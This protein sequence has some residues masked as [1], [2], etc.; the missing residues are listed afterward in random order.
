MIIERWLVSH[1]IRPEQSTREALIKISENKRGFL[2]CVDDHFHVLGGVT[3][4]DIRRY[5]MNQ[6]SF[7]LDTPVAEIFNPSVVT[8]DDGM[9]GADI[10]ALFS[11]VIQFVP[12]VDKN[13]HLVGIAVPEAREMRFGDIT[14]SDDS[15]CFVIAEIGINHNGSLELAKQLVDL[16]ADSGAD[17]AK[18]QMRDMESLYRNHS[19][20]VAANEDLGAQY[21]LDILS[22]SH[23][24][25]DE[26]FEVFDYCSTRGLV[27]LCTPWDHKSLR[28]LENYGIPGYKIASADLTNHDLLIAVAETGR[29]IIMSTGMSSDSEI[30]DSCSL[31]RQNNAQFALL[32]CNSTY[33]APFKD[34]NLNYLTRLKSIGDCPVGYS[35]HERGYEVPVAAV[36][37]GAKIVEK[38]FTVDRN[39]EGNDHRVSLLPG[40]FADMVRS[41]RNVE[42]ALGTDS[43][44]EIT[45]GEL[46]NREN[47]SKSL[48]ATCDIQIGQTIDASMLGVKSPGQGLQP[49]RKT[50]LV[51]RQAR[52]DI[53][54]GEFFF[55]SDLL[56]TS[57]EPRDYSFNRP[58]GVPV[59]YHD[60]RKLG[61][62]SNLDFIEFH[63]SYKDLELD[64]AE[65]FEEPLDLDFVC[66]SPD[67][68]TGDHL[69]NL[70][71]ASNPEW[72]RSIDELQRVV[73][74]T[75]SL[76]EYF[77]KS[78]RVK[79]VASLGGFS[80]DKEL[81]VSDRKG[82]YDRVAEALSRVDTTGVEILPQTLPP[83]PW[84]FGGQLFCNL[85]VDAEDSVQ[86]CK[87]TGHRLCFDVCHSKLTCNHRSSSFYEF[88]E[89][90]APY[91]G[92][93]H[94]VDAKGVDAEGLQI[95]EGEMDFA[96]LANQLNIHCPDAGFIP[97]IWQGHKNGG[98][99]FWFALDRLEKWF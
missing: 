9:S 66:H 19:K 56:D 99:G 89:L 39:M 48:I 67:L 78:G 57:V 37:L 22:K 49:N 75:L 6:T 47:L 52:R 94:I 23:L 33:P 76:K 96:E 28:E 65:F 31:L 16:A 50:E 61:A 5:L 69:L 24:S 63:F 55:A 77:P 62:R 90:T 84:Y 45:Q 88:V 26:M 32:H 15:R 92:H 44:R 46:M 87:D 21:T 74:T 60:F 93:L 98:E 80:R 41:I 83:F 20:T 25:P 97:E 8:A 73:D 82:M 72:T 81:P 79:I 35:G 3:D 18:F 64:P 68:F 30:R 36:A 54:N 42:E 17:C 11:N 59:R 70:A 29:P 4:G 10:A 12:V 13:K 71:E 1:V 86:F 27:P 91:T 2:V 7:D 85:F 58:V 43:P 51:G 40:E 53:K 34:I 38:H 95:G 14:V